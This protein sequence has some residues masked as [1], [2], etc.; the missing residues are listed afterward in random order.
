MS[1]R[2]W[3]ITYPFA[4]PTTKTPRRTAE[5]TI[6]CANCRW[7]NLHTLRPTGEGEKSLSFHLESLEAVSLL[8]CYFPREIIGLWTPATHLWGLAQPLPHVDEQF[9][10]VRFMF[11]YELPHL[12]GGIL[13]E[14]TVGLWPIKTMASGAGGR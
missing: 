14:C 1:R 6:R 9:L 5:E 12:S 8:E 7:C 4:H 2:D 13:S 11:K 10:M 3:D